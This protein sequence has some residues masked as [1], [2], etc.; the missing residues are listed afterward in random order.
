MIFNESLICHCVSVFA[1]KVLP[2]L[3]LRLNCGSE[4]NGENKKKTTTK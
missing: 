1:K 3:L 2:Q 4:A